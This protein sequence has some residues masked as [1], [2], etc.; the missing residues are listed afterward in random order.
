MHKKTKEK[1]GE[2]IK[3]IFYWNHF[4]S[5]NDIW[6]KYNIDKRTVCILNW[7]IYKKT[8][9]NPYWQKRKK[10][11]IYDTIK[12]ILKMPLIHFVGN[13]EIMDLLFKIKKEWL[14]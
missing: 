7:L 4:Y 3:E 1:L 9:Y 10:V 8:A 11:Y 6:R 2:I 13:S 14:S 5:L 12:K